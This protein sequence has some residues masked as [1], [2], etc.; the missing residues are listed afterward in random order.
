MGVYSMTFSLA[1]TF[2][3]WLGAMVLQRFGPEVLWTATFVSGCMS[4]LLMSRIGAEPEPA[5]SG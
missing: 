4:A 3:P 5:Q 2:G 1:F